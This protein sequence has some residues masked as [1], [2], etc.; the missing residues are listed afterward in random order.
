[1]ASFAGADGFSALFFSAD[2]LSVDVALSLVDDPDAAFD[3]SFS[4]GADDARLSVLY[5]PDP[6]NTIADG[7]IRR[8]GRFPHVGHR[9]TGGSLYDRTTENAC[10]QWSQTWS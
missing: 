10:P 1:M 3:P 7:V 5:Q 4:A 6:L 8:R 2:L 9:S